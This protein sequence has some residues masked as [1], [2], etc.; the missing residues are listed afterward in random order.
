MWTDLWWSD[1][2][3]GRPVWESNQGQ[4]QLWGGQGSDEGASVV[5]NT[6]ARTGLRGR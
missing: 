4:Y 2:M 5:E 6:R 3:G 1:G